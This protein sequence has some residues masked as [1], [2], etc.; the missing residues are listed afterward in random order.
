VSTMCD[1][2]QDGEL[3]ASELGIRTVCRCLRH[4]RD[5]L[6]DSSEELAGVHGPHEVLVGPTSSPAVRSRGSFR[7]LESRMIGTV[8]P[9][10]SR[11]ARAL[12]GF[13]TPADC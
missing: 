5:Q 2:S 4:R 7:P 6:A 8:F 12:S 1:Q 10:S 9:Y 11:K 13:K 3:A